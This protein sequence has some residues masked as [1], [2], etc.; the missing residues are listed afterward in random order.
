LRITALGRQRQ[1]GLFAGGEWASANP[2]WMA[3][4]GFFDRCSVGVRL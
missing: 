1:A 4:A 2:V 3:V